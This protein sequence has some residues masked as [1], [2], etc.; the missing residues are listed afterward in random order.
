MLLDNALVLALALLLALSLDDAEAALAAGDA[1]A[2]GRLAQEALTAGALDVEDTARAW[3]LRGRCFARAGD[4]DRAERSFAVALRIDPALALDEP[5]FVAAQR[6]LPAVPGL[7]AQALF[8]D[9]DTLAVELLGDDLL[10]AHAASVR[11]GDHEVARVPLEAARAKHKVGGA[12]ADGREGLA[13][14]VLDKHGNALLRAPIEPRVQR[15]ITPAPGAAAARG[16]GVLTT[17]GATA[18]GAGIVGIVTSG[19]G[20]AALGPGALAAEEST[21]WVVGVGASTALFVV[22]A[23]LVVVDQGL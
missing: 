10:L 16:P 3:S 20:L 13:L 15:V 19:I 12:F 17:L 23:G 6:A 14:V 4:A 21:V 5:A 1:E 8:V 2:C 7:A 11:R 18:L 22:G 9:E